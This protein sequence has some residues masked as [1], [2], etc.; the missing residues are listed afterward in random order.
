MEI[1]TAKSKKL[2]LSSC[3]LDFGLASDELILFVKKSQRLKV[4][5]L[6]Y[7]NVNK[8]AANSI[9]SMIMNNKVLM[10]LSLMYCDICNDSIITICQAIGTTCIQTL[11]LQGNKI[12]VNGFNRMRVL[13]SSHICL[14]QM[15]SL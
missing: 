11:N 15:I 14:T 1:S 6:S 13:W 4:I 5:D 8:R 2:N 9:S 7:N 10:S 12:S 3:S